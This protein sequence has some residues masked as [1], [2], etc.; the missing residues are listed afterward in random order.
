LTRLL[1][2]CGHRRRTEE[3]LAGIDAIFA[4]A[5]LGTVPA[6]RYCG[7]GVELTIIKASD[8]NADTGT[9][10]TDLG[11]GGE[12]MSLPKHSLRL[13]DIPSARAGVQSVL[14]TDTLGT[15]T[16]LMVVNK[17]SQ[18][19]VIETGG[20]VRGV[21]TWQSIATMYTAKKE[22][23]LA[24]AYDVNGPYC[25][26]EHSDLFAQIP[27]ICAN[28]YALVTTN[29]TT[30]CGIVT[31]EDISR[32]FDATARPFFLVGRIE[33]LLR[34]WLAQLPEENVA[35]AQGKVRSEYRG[36]IDHCEFGHYLALL[37]ENHQNPAHR[38][39]AAPN[40]AALGDPD[41]DRTL[42]VH[43]LRRVKDIRN[44]I[45]HF[46][47]TPAGSAMTAEL[48]ECIESLKILV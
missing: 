39:N 40:W 3:A 9:T 37:D 23:T 41:I 42:L 27:A 15:A 20:H 32:Y 33:A 18:V 38:A 26:P 10:D 43:Q 35:K 4:A 24:N 13:M 22:S 7:H 8:L 25:V 48:L 2:M 30:I 6:Y 44:R 36:K 11:A 46:N 31:P 12:E 5:G 29:T 14:P 16:H 1:D 47:E 17:F 19:P 45:A 28:G 21:V 34:Q